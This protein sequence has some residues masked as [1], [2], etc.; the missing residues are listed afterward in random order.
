MSDMSKLGVGVIGCG[1]ISTIYL[2]NMPNFRDLRL[3]ACADLRPEVA[4]DQAGPFGIEALTIEA[5]L[6]RP[7]I[8]IVV[9]LTT[10]N[11]HF[12]VS[13][14][15]LTAGKHVFGEKPI[16][17][18]AADAAALVAEAAQR[19]LK[20]GCAPDTFLGGGGR[21]ARELVDAGRI[22]KVLYGTCFLMSHGM[23]HWHPDPTFFF[24]PGGGPILDMGPYY[25]AALINLL[26]SV[27]HVQGRASSGFA[28]RL[29]SSKGPM[30]GKSIPVETPT[31]VM[32]L[33]HFETGA[34]IVFTMSWDVWKHGHA[35]IELY[36]TEGS[37]RVPDPNFFGGVVQYT[38]K[39]SDWIS[40]AADDRAFGK[41]NWR[42]PNWPDHM[43]S[44]A[45]YRC[46]GVAD[47]A[48]AVLHGTPHRASGALA[49]HALEV[50]HATLK[51]GV[52]GG[53]IAVQSRVDR[54]AAMSETDALALWA[55]E[56]F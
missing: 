51:A 17:V 3:V 47:L 21:T 1:N 19:G 40:L 30:N 11:A 24:K 7:D 43:P 2:R 26:G 22:G 18:E 28:T 55:A 42:S 31:T 5:L 49:S 14:A 20:L 38:E 48:S 4:R 10:P 39:S 23:E 36:G 54:P 44:Q 45:N 56:T 12:A 52:E 13:H 35:P 9:N 8:Q 29:V 32:A 46:L 16:T 34:D 50:M 15:A 25:L 33:L 37:L 27:T 41:P 6:A 53:E